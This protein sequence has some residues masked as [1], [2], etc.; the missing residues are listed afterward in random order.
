ML[1]HSLV[2]F[3][4]IVSTA[5]SKRPNVLFIVAD[6]L[7]PSLKSYGDKEAY[8]PHIDKFAAN[9]F[10]FKNAFA[11]QALCAP[12]RNSL[13]TSRRPDSLHLYDFYS[14]WRHTVGNFTTLPQH[15]KENGY[16]THSVGKIF[17]PGKSSNFTDD[18]PHS[19]STKT[20][21][22][23][24]EAYI[25]AKVC[26]GKDG[27]RHMN[28]I[29]PVIPT[30]Q[31]GGT[32]PDMESFAEALRFLKYKDQITGNKPYFL[33]V[34][35]H[36]PHIPLKFPRWYLKYHPI[37]NVSL[38]TNRWRPTSLPTVA[39]NPWTDIRRR[40]DIRQLNVS[41]PFGPMPDDIIKEI[42]Q[43]YYASVTY[44]DDLIG[45][46]VSYAD[47]DTI[48]VL[49]SD[50][51]W[52]IGEHG[53]F[54]KYSNFDVATRVPLLIRVPGLS[55][56]KVIVEKPVELV[57]IFPTLVDLTQVSSPLKTCPEKASEML[58]TEG[59]SLVPFMVKKKGYKLLPSLSAFSQYPR[60][61]PFPTNVP[62]SDQPKLKDIKIM[63]YSLRTEQYRYTE[64]VDFSK[65]TFKPDWNTVYG[66]E[67][68]DHA[69]DAF[70]NYN[71][72]DRDE[73]KNVSKYLR[74]KLILGWRHV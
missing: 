65:E 34:G 66:R 44:I 16:Y 27:V 68:Y 40:D 35:F 10:I 26:I 4:F 5:F 36:K 69:M 9:S 73:L 63:G 38:P 20:F 39:W 2:F 43:A 51:G 72:V 59:K 42:K 6:D 56:T 1:K 47:K 49:T 45:N 30:Y 33:A 28:L 64:W 58:C 17:H 53:E 37:D 3:T 52:S 13:L 70:E 57:D 71:L 41:F 23:K 19:W 60:P 54:A 8:T 22:P 25:N 74:N 48:V 50:H 55:T 31:P 18:F 46:L 14:Y 24:T 29:C 15:F 21:H 7:R 67:L 61:G 12:S 62:N 11:Q 32:L